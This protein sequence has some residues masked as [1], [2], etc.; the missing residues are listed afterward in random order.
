VHKE[1]GVVDIPD[2]G[3]GTAE[4]LFHEVFR[5]ALGAETELFNQF[6]AAIR[7]GL[8]GSTGWADSQTVLWKNGAIVCDSCFQ[9]NEATER[10]INEGPK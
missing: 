8:C 9:N 7:C 5:G 2:G 3:Y 4:D 6:I 10:F 1:G